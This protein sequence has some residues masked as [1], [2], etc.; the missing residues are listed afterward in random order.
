MDNP[1]E[2]LTIQITEV[3]NG[4]KEII[5]LLIE[6][7]AFLS[8]D[9]KHGVEDQKFSIQEL[10]SYLKRSDSTINRY[11]KNNLFPFYSAGRT[12]F[13]LK[14]EVDEAMSSKSKKKRLQVRA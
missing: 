9:K 10:C 2:V 3:M 11:K 12:V 5:N 6:K 14:S 1:F 7:N 4:Q 13:F 8:H